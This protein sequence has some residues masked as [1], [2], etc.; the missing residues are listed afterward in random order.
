[1]NSEKKPNYFREVLKFAGEKKSNYILSVLLAVCGA[2]CQ[3]APFFLMAR[4]V[5]RLLGGV[6]EFSA[7]VPDLWLMV[8]AWALRVLFHGL[9]TSFSHVGT[10]HVL[11]N[12][13]RQGLAKL[14][15]MPLGDVSGQGSGNLKNI[16]VERID[17]VETTL[18]HVIPEVSSNL[19]VVLATLVYLLILNWKMALAALITLPIG[20]AFYFLIMIG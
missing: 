7:Y 12:I 13:R 16:L 1:M 2:F 8:L 11:G 3:M 10:F 19:S 4:V 14:E 20:M 15:R 18:A 6:T 5:V 17:S 9:S